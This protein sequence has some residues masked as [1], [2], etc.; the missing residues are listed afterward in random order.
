MFSFL[1]NAKEEAA[2]ASVFSIEFNLQSNTSNKL[3][4]QSL[5]YVET[6][7]EEELT[8]LIYLPLVSDDFSSFSF[9]F[10]KIIFK[11]VCE[12][13]ETARVWRNENLILLLSCFRC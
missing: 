2:D 4:F 12:S 9:F 13:A 11:S 5:L 7:S 8:D 1:A 3:N 10:S 6:E